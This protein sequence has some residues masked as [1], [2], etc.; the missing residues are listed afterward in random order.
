[1][2]VLSAGQIF[3][4]RLMA[5]V[6]CCALVLALSSDFGVLRTRTIAEQA[7]ALD[8]GRAAVARLD[9]RI[10]LEAQRRRIDESLRLALMMA[11]EDP[12]QW[13]LSL[14]ISGTSVPANLSIVVSTDQPADTRVL[15][16][17]SPDNARVRAEAQVQVPA[18]ADALEPKLMARSGE[19]EAVGMD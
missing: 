6:A 15:G 12:S 2:F 19:V 10:P 9:R 1:M 14:M 5:I 13:H 3:L 18:P 11:G 4:M 7:L 16:F 17:L 8:V